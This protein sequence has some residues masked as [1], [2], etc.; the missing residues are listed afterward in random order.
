MVVYWVFHQKGHRC[1]AD[2]ILPRFAFFPKTIFVC[3]ELQGGGGFKPPKPPL[4]T[5]GGGAKCPKTS[6]RGGGGDLN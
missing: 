1:G 3:Q 4:A 2:D 6:L 5:T